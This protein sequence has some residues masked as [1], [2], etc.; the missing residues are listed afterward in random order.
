V[1]ATRPMTAPSQKCVAL[2]E[3]VRSSLFARRLN[4]SNFLADAFHAQKKKSDVVPP[5]HAAT[6]G[7]GVVSNCLY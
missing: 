4:L 5:A 3:G 7:N 1:I 2:T 6:L